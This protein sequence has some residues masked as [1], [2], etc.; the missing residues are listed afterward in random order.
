M[1]PI[2]LLFSAQS[3]ARGFRFSNR[4]GRVARDCSGHSQLE[5]HL[6]WPSRGGRISQPADDAP[7]PALA[8]STDGRR[9]NPRPELPV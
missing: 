1:A 9:D 5:R 8:H 3:R 7:R 6:A 4:E 2:K